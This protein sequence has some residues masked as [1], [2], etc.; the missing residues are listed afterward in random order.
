MPDWLYNQLRL[1]PTVTISNEIDPSGRTFRVERVENETVGL[2]PVLAQLLEQ[3]RGVS[4]AFLC[5]PY[6]KYV[7]KMHREGGF[8]GYRN[9]QMMVSFIQGI[10]LP[11]HEY[12]PGATPSILRL[13]DMIEEAWDDGY[14][15]NGRIETG[16]IKGTRKYI[17]TP[18]ASLSTLAST[19]LSC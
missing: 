9:I 16:G 19:D 15:S 11:G 4:K 14:N 1:G 6:V 3:D 12:F 2:I 10:K 17:G 13:Q 7:T 5:H 8:C 18:E